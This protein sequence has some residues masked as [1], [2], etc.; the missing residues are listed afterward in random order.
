MSEV[1]KVKVELEIPKEMSEIKFFL[2]E[3]LKDIKAKKDVTQLIGENIT[4]LVAA[5]DGFEKLDDE[6]KDPS[7][8]AFG[9]ILAGEIVEVLVKK[10]V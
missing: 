7:I 3:L 8:Y 9:G 1:E 10:E 5:V 6:V 2:V 4:N